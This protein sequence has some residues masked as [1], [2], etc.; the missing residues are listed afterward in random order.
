MFLRPRPARY[1]VYLS[2]SQNAQVLS[3]H[4]SG[5]GVTHLFFQCPRLVVER[6]GHLGMSTPQ[7]RLPNHDRTPKEGL[8]FLVLA[9]QS[10]WVRV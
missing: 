1:K 5:G 6:Y 3:W 7:R 9:L 2:Q 4:A 8:G 10:W